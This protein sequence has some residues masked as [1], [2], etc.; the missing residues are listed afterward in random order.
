VSTVEIRAD[1]S[2]VETATARLKELKNEGNATATAADRVESSTGRANQAISAAAAVSGQAAAAQTKLNTS[3]SQGVT[4][5]QKFTSELSGAR[6]ALLD[7]ITQQVKAGRVISDTGEVLNA[8]GTKATEATTKYAKLTGQFVNLQNTADNVADAMER[9]AQGTARNVAAAQ[10]AAAAEERLQQEAREVAEQIEKQIGITNRAA[11]A[12]RAYAESADVAAAGAGRFGAKAAQAGIQIEQLVTSLSAGAPIAQSFAFQA[13]DLGIV[14]GAPLIGSIVAVSAALAGPF[15]NSLFDG[16]SAS[17]RLADA[18]DRVDRVITNSNSGGII[19]YTDAIRELAKVSEEA[20]RGRLRAAILDAEDAARAASQGIADS[21]QDA[22]D[23]GDFIA[24]NLEDAISA[25]RAAGDSIGPALTTGIGRTLENNIADQLGA[26]LGGTTEEARELGT[27]IVNLIAA[28][29]QFK[30]P[31]A[32]REIEERLNSLAENATPRT[33]DQIDRL[34][35]SISEFVDKGV[36]AGDK[37]ERLNFDVSSEGTLQTEPVK[38]YSDAVDSLIQQLTIQDK[39]LREGELAGQLYAAALATGK[40]SVDD[41]DPVIVSLIKSIYDQKQASEDAAQAKRDEAA[42][43]NDLR[44]ELAEEERARQAAKK[45]LE[46]QQRELERYGAFVRQIEAENNPAERARQI[47]EERLQIIQDHYGFVSQLEAEN[48]EEGI[49]ALKR[50][51]EALDDLKKKTENGLFDDLA[52][53]M[54]SLSNTVSGTAASVALGFQDGEDAAA[55]LARTI[56]TQLLGTVINW[57][58]ET[59]ASALK[60][61]IA[62]QTAEA[63]KTAAITGAIGTQTAA[64]TTAAGVVAGAQTAA[65]TTIGAAAAPAAAAT[66]IATGGGAAIS[67]TAIALGGIAAILAALAIGG[68]SQGGNVRGGQLYRVNEWDQEFFMPHTD[69]RIVTPRDARQGTAAGNSVVMNNVMNVTTSSVREF[70]R[71]RSR[72]QLEAAQYRG[73]QRAYERNR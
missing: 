55:S 44:K 70:T 36:E 15:I 73:Y 50:Y 37:L 30:T 65:V 21:F 9:A 1:S 47:Y 59:A 3:L 42:A 20:A 5:S 66:S 31:E 72:R 13:A 71:P 23:L 61:M 4:A 60:G 56:G 45:A 27:E 49:A 19:E 29:E 12:R 39:T 7:F 11:A 16:A 25:A 22:F 52:S 26:A 43:N 35:G 57:G 6:G 64:A 8:N 28:A 40:E 58:I 34:I 18:L 38:N 48:T 46:D 51:E 2:Q 62:T 67:G 10:A 33:R 14:L 41:L 63:G 69:G 24:G 32:F 68:R 53:E 17:D 54:D